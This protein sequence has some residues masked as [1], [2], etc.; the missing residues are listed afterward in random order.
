MRTPTKWQSNQ[1]VDGGRSP[2]EEEEWDIPSLPVKSD[3][4]YEVPFQNSGKMA[5]VSKLLSALD[6]AVDTPILVIGDLNDNMKENCPQFLDIFCKHGYQQRVQQPTTESGSCLDVVWTKKH[7]VLP[8]DIS[9]AVIPMF[10]SFHDAVKIS[11]PLH[12]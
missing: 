6:S 3:F 4:S 5:A 7:D 2:E 12:H 1:P 11:I 9:V 8:G 10:Y